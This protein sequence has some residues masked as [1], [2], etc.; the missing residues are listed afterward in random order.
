MP[1]RSHLCLL[2]VAVSRSGLVR[3][4]QTARQVSSDRSGVQLPRPMTSPP[5]SMSPLLRAAA[6]PAAPSRRT[7]AYRELS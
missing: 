2:D 1:L 6:E 5:Y 4:E 3:I 7:K